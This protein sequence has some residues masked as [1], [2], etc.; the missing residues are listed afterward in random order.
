MKK[1]LAIF[2]AVTVMLSFSACGSKEADTS[3]GNE[4]V[5]DTVLIGGLAPL[6]GEVA[7]YGTTTTNGA[8]LA[9][10]EIN[11]N[12]GI[13]GGKKIEYKVMDE[14]GDSVEAINAF[15]KLVDD[16]VVAVLG[17]VT[18]KPSIAVAEASAEIGLPVISATA[19]HPDVTTYGEN[20]FRV[21]FL[22]P[23][24]GKTM[25]K[26][27]ADTVKAKKVAVMYNT[28]DD[29]SDGVAKAFKESAE[30]LGL[31]VT[32]F[33]GYGAADIDF[34]T[35]LTKIAQT[36]PDAILFPDYYA[37]V[38]LIVEQA[39][40][41]GITS[42]LLGADGW[43][44]VAATV[45]AGNKEVLENTYFCNHYSVQDTSER[46]QSFIKAY[47]DKYGEAPSAFAALGYDAAYVLANAIDK[48]GSTEKEAVVTAIAA[49]EYDGVTG[50]MTFDAERNPI[51]SVSIIKIV[52]GEYSF[53]STVM[54]E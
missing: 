45:D 6:T 23:F 53:D 37:K 51:K 33:E 34:K 13:L 25:S 54:P 15:N 42:T 35:Q 50:K 39:R 20:V 3:K 27:A 29:Y 10:E 12:G 47:T 48:A 36:K 5:G 38:A 9:F 2:M 24:Q 31:E 1:A 16:G 40:G 18:S 22:D 30:Q 44:G 28:S 52:N 43:D 11:A 17:D 49:T 4:T 14:K 7:V 21:C 8:N 26:F 41:V 19:T 46:V 32:A